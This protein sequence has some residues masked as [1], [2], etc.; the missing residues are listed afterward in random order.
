[1]PQ[2]PPE[3]IDEIPPEFKPEGE[4]VVWIPGYWWWDE[5]AESHIWI[6]G[7]WRDVPPDQNWVAGYWTEAD[8]GFQWVS[9]FFTSVAHDQLVYQE[10]PPV[11]LEQGPISP[12][13]SEE[14]FWIPGHWDTG[15]RW[16][17]GFWSPLREDWVWI[18]ARWGATPHGCCF[19]PGHWDYQLA[20]RGQLFAPIRFVDPC[21]PAYVYRPTCVIRP[22][23]LSMHLF[24]RPRWRSYCFGDWYDECSSGA[25]FSYATFHSRRR[26]YCP[27]FAHSRARYARSGI[28]LSVRLGSWNSYFTRNRNHRPCRTLA[29]QRVFERTYGSRP[30]AGYCRLGANIR[31]LARLRSGPRGR[32]GAGANLFADHGPQ[33]RRIS[34]TQVARERQTA[35]LIRTVATE[36]RKRESVV[37]KNALVGRDV[38]TVRSSRRGSRDRVNIFR[39]R[40][41]DRS[42]SKSKTVVSS[43]SLAKTVRDKSVGKGIQSSIGSKV[44]GREKLV[45]VG[46]KL[47]GQ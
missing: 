37:G 2:A 38:A 28:N 26:G 32:S 25:L 16:N 39:D 14:H 30:F 33:L 8:N 5:D 19:V 11:S 47:P 23:L 15:Y 22:A 24:V 9:G 29:R 3:L 6:S 10:P 36:R 45:G 43:K 12:A 42:R 40:T 27:L 44:K 17:A 34:S 31:D 1:M 7:V 41:P 18:P 20:S 13:P 46:P 4:N 21:P 35:K